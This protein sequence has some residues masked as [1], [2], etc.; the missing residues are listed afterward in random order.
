MLLLQ[1]WYLFLTDLQYDE[2]KKLYYTMD[3]DALAPCVVVSSTV[4]VI[5]SER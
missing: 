1:K 5:S 4:I 2:L 3:A